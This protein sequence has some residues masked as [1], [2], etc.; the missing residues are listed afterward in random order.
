MLLIR[1]KIIISM[2]L[3]KCSGVSWE[4]ISFVRRRFIVRIILYNSIILIIMYL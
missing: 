2:Y 3:Y 4:I 1:P